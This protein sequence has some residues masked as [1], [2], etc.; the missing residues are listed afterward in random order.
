MFILPL[1][2]LETFVNVNVNV[3]RL[4]S[5]LSFLE[6]IFRQEIKFCPQFFDILKLGSCLPSTTPLMNQHSI[7]CRPVDRGG[8]GR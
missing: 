5:N 3:R 1:N 8:V 7:T 4:A 2:V 6:K